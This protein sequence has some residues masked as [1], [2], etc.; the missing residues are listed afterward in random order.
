MK[1]GSAG[2]KIFSYRTFAIA[3]QNLSLHHITACMRLRLA[4][5]L[6]KPSPIFAGCTASRYYTAS[7][8]RIH[9]DVDADIARGRSL[10]LRINAFGNNSGSARRSLLALCTRAPT[11]SHNTEYAKYAFVFARFCLQHF[12]YFAY[13]EGVRCNKLF[14]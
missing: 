8:H 13:S 12:A 5:Y 6:R 10:L 4:P 2:H 14:S 1:F 9:A 3:N 7:K 11:T